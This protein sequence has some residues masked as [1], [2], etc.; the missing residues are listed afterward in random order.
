M[1]HV[2]PQ[3]LCNNCSDNRHFSCNVISQYEI[4]LDFDQPKIKN[5]NLLN[6][7][8]VIF[9]AGLIALGILTCL[10]YN[11]AYNVALCSLCACESIGF[12]TPNN[13]FKSS[14][15][16]ISIFLIAKTIQKKNKPE[17]ILLLFSN[18]FIPFFNMN[19]EKCLTNT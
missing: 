7:S 10:D 5:L 19:S 14:I 16:E 18:S 13:H 9:S 6:F 12:E 11:S 2:A 4:P 1:V 17:T 8:I 15:I 3:I